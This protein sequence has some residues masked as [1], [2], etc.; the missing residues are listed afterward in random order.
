[1]QQLFL[2]K[3]N[4]RLSDR[5]LLTARAICDEA[6][7]WVKDRPDYIRRHNI[8]PRFALPDANWS[9][10][11]PNEFVRLFR[12]V[13]EGDRQTLS[14]LRGLAPVFSGYHLYAVQS[15]EGLI[16]ADIEFN[17]TLD[18]SIADRLRERNEPHVNEWQ[19]LTYKIPRR[20]VFS[21]APML[22]EIGHDLDGVIVNNDTC[23]YQERVNLILGSGLADWLDRRIEATGELKICEIGG[24]YGALASWFKQAYPEASY[25]IIDLPESLLF[26][27]LYLSLTRPDLRTSAGFSQA[28]RG[29]RFM[30]N[31]L[32]EGLTEPFDLVINTLSMSEMSEFQIRRYVEL[33]KQHWLSEGGLFFEQNQDNRPM[34]LECAE[35]VFADEFARRLSLKTD[36]QGYRNGSP[37]IWSMSPFHLERRPCPAGSCGPVELIE[38]LGEFNLVR[39][40]VFWGL[41]K[42]L[43][44][45]DPLTLEFKDEP[46]CIF[47]GTSAE[48]IKEKVCASTRTG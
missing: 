48:A 8:D 18:Q 36:G 39:S 46:P 21:P 5:E 25:T 22:G 35:Q 24:G 29:F 38:D 9:Y 17:D 7:E 1:V 44:P 41:R 12:R 20:F 40:S 26:S 43:G 14:H 19:Q 31:Y 3:N 45:T 37:N 32:A 34:G 42:D 2:L 27:R 23:T 6:V 15:S 33:L 4:R 28:P 16:A 47:A 10:D 11:A 30:P 13:A